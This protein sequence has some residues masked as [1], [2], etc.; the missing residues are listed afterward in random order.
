MSGKTPAAHP[1]A[2][3]PNLEQPRVG[4]RV[5]YAN[6]EFFAAKERLIEPD[7]PVFIKG[8]YDDHGKWMDGWETRRKR[9][10]GHDHCIIRLGS[11]AVVHGFDIDTTFFTGNYPPHAS[12]DACYSGE[13]HPGDD[14][15]WREILPKT[16]LSGDSHHLLAVNDGRPLTHLRL[17]IYPDGGIARLRV[18]GEVRPDWGRHDPQQVIDLFA[19]E[20]GGRALLCNN[21]HF[22]S[23]HRMNVPGRAL[24]MGDSWGTRRRREPGND[25]VIIALGHPG[26]IEKIDFDTNHHKG[27]YPDRTSIQAAYVPDA[28]LATLEADS[29]SWKVL[30]PETKLEAH[31][32]H[33][34]TSELS[35]LGVVSHLRVSIYPDGGISRLRI[36]GRIAKGA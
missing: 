12:I 17:N 24:T 36:Y 34:F 11:P 35:S 19:F 22:S 14:A 25:W 26:V 6:D 18:Y 2:Q 4:T 10:P 31:K 1:F 21:Q 30:L 9:G 5:V 8:K 13:E 28:N 16:A 15:G 29:A 23:M 7:E 33:F 3:W 32:Q 27:N 20:N